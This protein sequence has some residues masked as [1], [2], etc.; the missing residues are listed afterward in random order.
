MGYIY[1]LVCLENGRYTIVG[2]FTLPDVSNENEIRFGS[3]FDKSL[4]PDRDRYMNREELF[5]VIEKFL[6]ANRGKL[7][8][9]IPTDEIEDFHDISITN[10]EYDDYQSL[11]SEPLEVDPFLWEDHKHLSEG[12]KAAIE[13]RV[14]HPVFSDAPMKK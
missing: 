5:T 7:I 9:L 1:Q 4:T 8:A 10:D 11:T 13:K 12:V 3:R 6:I 2:K 14:G